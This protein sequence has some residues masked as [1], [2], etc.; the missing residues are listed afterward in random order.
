MGVSVRTDGAS[1]QIA[2][3]TG[4][5]DPESC[6][7]SMQQQHFLQQLQGPGR[8][9]IDCNYPYRS[10]S[11][12]Y[13]HM[14]LWRASVSNARQ[15]LAARAARVADA[16]R[17]RV[18]ALLEQAP[19]TVLLAGSCGLQLLTALQ[20]PQALRTRLAVFAYGP[21]CN[22]PATF[23]HLRVVQGSGDWIS[24]ALCAGAPD[25]MPACGHLHYLRDAAVLAEC[26]A[27]IAQVEQPVQGR[28]HAH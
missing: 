3:L 16:D 5:S 8:R 6:A 23:G 2:F 1:L 13:R 9:L 7:L 21:V 17:T 14:P 26:Q 27:F 24:R 25:L 20:L 28:E 4:Q 11:P 22:A 12:T 15:Y 10:A 18:V 19:T